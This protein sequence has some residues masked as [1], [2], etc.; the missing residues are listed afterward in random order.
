M[1]YC[2]YREMEGYRERVRWWMKEREWRRRRLLGLDPS[3]W[4][5]FATLPPPGRN[6]QQQHAHQPPHHLHLHPASARLPRLRVHPP[7]DPALGPPGFD[8]S[9]ACKLRISGSPIAPPD[10]H[11]AVWRSHSESPHRAGQAENLL[12]K[13]FCCC[14]F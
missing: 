4:K 13:N 7:A 5:Q 14:H 10:C 2:T 9:P 11:Q 1:V 12:P 8:L 6:H 3:C